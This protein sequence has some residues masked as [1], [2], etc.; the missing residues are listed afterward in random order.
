MLFSNLSPHY[1]Y[2]NSDSV[3]K[4]QKWNDNTTQQVDLALNIFFMV[5]FFI[6]VRTALH[7]SVSVLR[8]PP[9]DSGELLA[10][11]ETLLFLSHSL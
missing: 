8:C 3:E 2:F 11:I 4:C 5:Y 10:L 1:H 9:F 7:T 6:R